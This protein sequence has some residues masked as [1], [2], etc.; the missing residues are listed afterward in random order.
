MGETVFAEAMPQCGPLPS[1]D[2]GATRQQGE[3]SDA[4]D[5]HFSTDFAAIVADGLY[6]PTSAP[7]RARSASV[8]LIG[9]ALLLA[10]SPVR[11][12]DP[13]ADV[14]R[15]VVSLKDGDE[16]QATTQLFAAARLGCEK[17]ARALLDRGAA[18]G[19]RDR[20]GNTALARAAQKGKIKL[21]MLLLGKGAE[22]NARSVNGSTPL[23]LAAEA[24]RLPVVQALLERGADPNVPGRSGLRPLAAAAYNG[25][26]ES[27]AGLLKRG[28]DPNALDDDGKSA[29]VYAAGRAYASIVAQ[30]IGAGVDVNR[31]YGHGLTALMWA[32]GHDASAGIED[33]EATLRL[34]LD[35]GALLDLRDDRGQTA[36][37]I[38]R[39]LGREREGKM[40]EEK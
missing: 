26:E 40:L 8:G 30:L 37:D 38:A 1:A 32:A 5:S 25:S 7:H 28:A 12:A 33:V 10:A 31:R 35:R 16:F 23:F 13:C 11:A 4:L 15:A 21:V 29:M 17:E 27:V 36:G 14:A 24:D 18:I 39:G 20:E 22:I 9:L 2:A 34:L 6:L 3:S 19:A